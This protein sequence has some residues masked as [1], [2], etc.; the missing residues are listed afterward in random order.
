MLTF[1]ELIYRVNIKRLR[2]LVEFDLA[3]YIKSGSISVIRLKNLG[4]DGEIGRW[5]DWQMERFGIIVKMEHFFYTKPK[6]IEY[7]I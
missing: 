3:S 6:R 4:G 2:T 7:Y 5:G 1:L